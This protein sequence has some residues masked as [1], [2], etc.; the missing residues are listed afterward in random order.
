MWILAQGHPP[1]FHTLPTA[2]RWLIHPDHSLDPPI[3]HRHLQGEEGNFLLSQLGGVA[4]SP[5]CLKITTTRGTCTTINSHTRHL[6]TLSP[7]HVFEKSQAEVTDKLGGSRTGKG[8]EVLSCNQNLLTE[9]QLW[10]S[11]NLIDLQDMVK[12]EDFAYF[13]GLQGRGLR[14][15]SMAC[16]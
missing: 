2:P 7:R 6:R 15:P 4:E 13:L 10:H 9:T 12:C 11:T 1:S 5:L 8:T 3:S 16:V 14:A